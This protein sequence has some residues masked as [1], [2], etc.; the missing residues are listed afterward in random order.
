LHAA[1]RLRTLTASMTAKVTPEEEKL[2]KM[3]AREAGLT[4]SEW[5]RQALIRAASCTPETRLVLSELM[6]LRMVLLTLHT[7]LLQG[8][9][10]TGERV[11]EALKQADAR[12]YAMADGRID[13]YRAETGRNQR[14]EAAQ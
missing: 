14:G 4:P 9:E 13:L 5:C 7:D 6:A 1:K 11:A 3:Q 2:F 12:K 10:V 8:H